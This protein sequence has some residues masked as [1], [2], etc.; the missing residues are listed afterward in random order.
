M[1]AKHSLNLR[2]RGALLLTGS[3]VVRL[4]LVKSS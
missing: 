1:N 2:L 4:C 3:A